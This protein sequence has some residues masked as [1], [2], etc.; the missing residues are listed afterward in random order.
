MGYAVVCPVGARG[1]VLQ[2][3]AEKGRGETQGEV[4]EAVAWFGAGDATVGGPV[5]KREELAVVATPAVGKGA[6]VEVCG[7]AE[8]S[9]FL[10]GGVGAEGVRK[11]VGDTNHVGAFAQ[12]GS[13]HDAVVPHT[14]GVE[15]VGYDGDFSCTEAHL[16][17]EEVV[18]VEDARA[19]TQV[20]L[21]E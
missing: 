1:E 9:G 19:E 4:E 3:G 6:L 2:Q 18:L 16:R 7:E 5:D 12:V 8:E 11:F 17:G 10:D 21:G 15:Y 13:G 14:V 20:V